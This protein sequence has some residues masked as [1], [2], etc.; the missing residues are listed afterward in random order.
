MYHTD[1][2]KISLT[3]LIKMY[4]TLLDKLKIKDGGAAHNRLRFLKE[5]KRKQLFNKQRRIYNA[6][7]NNN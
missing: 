1:V 3:D 5:K 6:T 7:I 4:E 2:S